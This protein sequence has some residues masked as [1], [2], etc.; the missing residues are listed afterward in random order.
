MGSVLIERV[1]N[2]VTRKR[3]C[4]IMSVFDIFDVNFMR[5]AVRK[6]FRRSL[7]CRFHAIT[8]FLFLS[9]PVIR[10]DIL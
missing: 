8:V 4:K 1:Y 2:C 3:V 7:R 9:N 5:T 6:N 10:F